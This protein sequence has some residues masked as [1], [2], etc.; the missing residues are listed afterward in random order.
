MF[1]STGKPN[2]RQ[3]TLSLVPR[4]VFSFAFSTTGAN[5]R[6][7]PECYKLIFFVKNVSE[8]RQKW[9]PLCHLDLHGQVKRA[10]MLRR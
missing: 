6:D 1:P 8:Q 2:L 5:V 10:F 3:E 9:R 7:F 4:S